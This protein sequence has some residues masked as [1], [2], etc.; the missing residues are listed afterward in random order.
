MLPLEGHR[1]VGSIL[2]MIQK[3][4]SISDFEML[5]KHDNTSITLD[6]RFELLDNVIQN[7]SVLAACVCGDY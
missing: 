3:L 1:R 5:R 6:I 2:V 4:I 7:Q